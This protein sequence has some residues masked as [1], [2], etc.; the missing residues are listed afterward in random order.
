MNV[1]PFDHPLIWEGHA[2]L[3]REL[4]ESLGTPPG[5]VVLAVGGGGLLAGVTAGLLEVGWQH[6]P[7]V[8]METR[9]AHSFNAALKAGRLV[10]LPDITSVARSLGAKTVAARTLECAKECEVL[11]EVVEDQEAVSAVQRFLD[12][13]RMLVEPACGAALAAVYSGILGRL[14][15]EGRLSPSLA[16]VVVIVCGGNN[17]SSQQLQELKTQLGCS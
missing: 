3:V 6:V 10:T 2:S 8:A 7:I 1:S 13:E 15:A 17:I 16:P 11:S 14:Q 5:A 12:D 4:K 9:G